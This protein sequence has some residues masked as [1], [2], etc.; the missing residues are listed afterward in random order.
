MLTVNDNN[1]NGMRIAG[2]TA[3]EVGGGVSNAMVTLEAPIA[4]YPLTQLTNDNG[5]YAFNNNPMNADYMVTVVK[6]DNHTN[7]VSTLDL[8]LIQ[9]HIVGFAD[10]DSPYKVIAADINSDEKVS[11]IDVVE[12]RKVILGI[13]EEFSANTS[14]RFVDAG[15]TFADAL[16]PWPIDEEREIEDLVANMNIEHFVAVKIGDVNATAEHNVAGTTTEVR[17]STPMILEIE[18][19]TVTAGEVVEIAINSE[20]FKT[21]SGLQA[22]IEFNGM[23]FSDVSGR[24]I[25][26]RASNVGV[27]SDNVITMSWNT[28]TAVS[29]ADEALFVITAIATADG[30]LSEMIS[31]TDRVITPEVYTGESLTIQPLEL[32]TRDID[33]IT[34][35]NELMQNEPNPFK[36][37]TEI[38]FSLAESGSAT[39]TIMDV[40]GKVLHTITDEYN[41]GS[42]TIKLERS[43]VQMASGVIYYTLESG[44]Y[45]ETM[46]MIVID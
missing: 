14:W 34:G 17:S 43:D 13:Q 1:P 28:N 32:S 44:D 31:I 42:N 7:G 29:T 21:V 30:Q 15:Q 3:T 35:V 45:S 25:D 19:R 20:E 38:K 36:T 40:T 4:E 2:I 11:S 37:V 6:D 27:I 16:Q 33:G 39:M 23:T 8:V 10:L 24:A 22:T 12:L 41:A 46:K 26:V 18:E 5:A 9:R